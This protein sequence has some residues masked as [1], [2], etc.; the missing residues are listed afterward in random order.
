M[1]QAD[2]AELEILTLSLCRAANQAEDTLLRLRN[3]TAEM[4]EDLQLAEFPQAADAIESATLAAAGIQRTTDTLQ[5]LRTVMQSV[6]DTYRQ[7]E[8]AHRNALSRMLSVMEN[9]STGY[10]AALDSPNLRPVEH[11]DPVTSLQNVQQLVAADAEEMQV[12]NIAS[13]A[14]IIKKEYGISAVSPMDTDPA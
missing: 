4:R 11:E 10:T 3:L 5:A 14:K 6:P 1:I 2:I 12:A 9:V 8:N 13:A 7:Q